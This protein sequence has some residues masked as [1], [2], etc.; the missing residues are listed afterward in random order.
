MQT[1]QLLQKVEEIDL[2]GAVMLLLS[3]SIGYTTTS[4]GFASVV[5]LLCISQTK[6]TTINV[7]AFWV[8]KIHERGSLGLNVWCGLTSAGAIKPF[9]FH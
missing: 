7:V 3:F 4:I 8:L 5:R 9:N 1:F 6:L 2:Y